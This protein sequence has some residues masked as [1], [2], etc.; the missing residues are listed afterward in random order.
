[1]LSAFTILLFLILASLGVYIYIFESST[2]EEYRNTI[3]QLIVLLDNIGYCPQQISNIL[4]FY[5]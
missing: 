2:L 4:S 3:R 5:D 1:M